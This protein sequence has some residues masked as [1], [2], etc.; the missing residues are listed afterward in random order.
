VRGRGRGRGVEER[1]RGRGNIGRGMEGAEKAEEI[2]GYLSGMSHGGT[3][4]NGKRALEIFGE[5]G[6]PL[7]PTLHIFVS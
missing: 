5:D 4:M 7:F 3:S 2:N 1:R 6:E